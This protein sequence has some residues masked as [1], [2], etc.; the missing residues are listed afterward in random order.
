MMGDDHVWG[1]LT[2]IDLQRHPAA[3]S[4]RAARSERTESGRV[5]SSAVITSGSI[6]PEN[7][8]SMLAQCWSSVVEAGPALNE[9]CANVS[10]LLGLCAGEIRKTYPE[11]KGGTS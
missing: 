3:G 8:S 5:R 10:C 9:N 4:D 6:S 7:T 1:Q 2:V 11:Y